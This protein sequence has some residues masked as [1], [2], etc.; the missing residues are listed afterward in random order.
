MKLLLGKNCDTSIK[1]SKGQ[2][3]K[4]FLLRFY[5]DVSP[6]F[7]AA[8]IKYETRDIIENARD[9]S[10]IREMMEWNWLWMTEIVNFFY[11]KEARKISF[12][13]HLLI[14]LIAVVTSLFWSIQ[15][16][17][18]AGILGLVFLFS[19]ISAQVFFAV[20]LMAD[21]GFVK[22]RSLEDKDNIIRRMLEEIEERRFSRIPPESE[23]CFH[24]LTKKPKHMNYCQEF[25]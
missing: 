18:D 10:E 4:D 2:T 24:T 17:S 14:T 13:L 9:F 15:S 19:L 5:D 11:K 22:S 3:P 12:V 8:Y 20:F 21:P 1:D 25:E 16:N 6:T 7:V 23:I